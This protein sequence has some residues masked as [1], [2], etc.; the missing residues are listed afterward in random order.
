MA[1]KKGKEKV[2]KVS[3]ETQF[4]NSNIKEY[5][6][7]DLVKMVNATSGD[8]DFATAYPEATFTRTLAYKYLVAKYDMDFV[9][10]SYVVPHGVTIDG[11]LE[12]YENQ[13]GCDSVSKET[14]GGGDGV[15]TVEVNMDT[16]KKRQTLSMNADTLQKWNEFTKDASK[17]SIYLTA[18]C[19]LFMRKA[20]EGKVEIKPTFI[21]TFE[22]MEKVLKG[23]VDMKT[24][25]FGKD[26]KKHD[27]ASSSDAEEF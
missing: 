20:M 6:K 15:D 22:R 18:A 24:I 17:K 14:Q 27:F 23:E 3:I 13:K 10:R 19:E 9:G 11:L 2:T 5:E 1:E 21:F 25:A 7:E 12:A 8:A 16:K 4:E 26:A